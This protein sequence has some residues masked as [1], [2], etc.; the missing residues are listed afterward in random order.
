MNLWPHQTKALAELALLAPGESVCVTSPTGG[1][2][3]LII[4]E[5][6]KSAQTSVL[7]TNRKMLLQQTAKRLDAAGIQH[8]I[9]AAGHESDFGQPHQLSS[10]QT[11]D[12]RVIKKGTWILHDS[13]LVQIDEAHVQKEAT[14][15]EIVARH[16][17][18][19]KST[20]IGYTA[21]PLGI[22]HLYDRLIV[23]GTNSELRAC[24]ALVP[25]Y[26]YGPDEPDM[27]N[28]KRTK[29][30]EY[31]QADIVKAI[32]THT[33]FGRVIDHWKQLNPEAKPTLLFAPGVKESLWFAQQLCDAGIPAAHIDGNDVWMDG[34][35]RKS[36]DEARDELMNRSRDGSIKIICNRFVLREGIDAPWLEC[37]IFATMFGALTSFVQSGG[38]LLRT[39]SGKDR[40][41]IIDHGGNWH[42]HGSLNSDRIWELDSTDYI[43]S[44]CREERMRQKKERE[45][46]VCIRCTMIRMSGSV[47]PGCGYEQHSRSRMVIQA[48]GNLKEMAGDIYNPRRTMKS[49]T[50][51]SIWKNHYYRARNRGATFNQARA[52][53]AY[54]NNWQ[55]PPHDLPLMPIEERD[56]FKRIKDVPVERLR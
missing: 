18:Y 34:E 13:Q 6:I 36:D 38:R 37:G 20:L 21:T 33:I 35:F 42:R 45:P 47:C 41:T 22:G 53:F 24:G 28:I 26:Q 1:G 40:A 14:A 25:A 16:R 51:G 39:H 54:E 50:A 23:A 15:C 19:H 32:M 9:R 2:K 52:L 43:V 10:I 17:K 11:E 44:E 7:Y 55:W 27:G 4:S 31:R 30:G 46:I 8:G 5:S 56:W 49:P 12:A 29:T 3:G 48:S